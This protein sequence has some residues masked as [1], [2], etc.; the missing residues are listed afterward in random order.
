MGITPFSCMND[1]ESSRSKHK[2]GAQSPESP[3]EGVMLR[4]RPVGRSWRGLR[5]L[6]AGAFSFLA[7]FI[8]MAVLPAAVRVGE[9]LFRFRFRLILIDERA[10]RA[11]L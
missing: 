6:D 4:R 3:S 5:L 10:R 9:V 11:Q 8:S 2:G 7:V 1:F